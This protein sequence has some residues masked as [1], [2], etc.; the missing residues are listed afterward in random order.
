MP[1]LY[2]ITSL[3]VLSQSAIF[4]RFAHSHAAAIGLWRMIIAV[5][6]LALFMLWKKRWG[7]IAKLTRKQWLLLFLCGFFLF[8]H[9]FTWFLSVQKTSL[10]NSMVLFASNPLY[11]ALGAWAIFGEKI[12][13]RHMIALALCFLGVYFLMHESLHG[14]ARNFEGDVLGFI[15]SVLFSAYILTSKKIRQNLDNIPFAF[16]TY[17]FVGLFFL[18]IVLALGLPLYD[19]D[20]QTYMAFIGLA[21]GSTLLG[22]SLFTHCLKF[23]NVNVMSISTLVEPI[24]TAYMGYLLFREPI[25]HGA[26]LGFIFV[27]AGMLVLYMPGL[28]RKK[29]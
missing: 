27:V 28:K 5:P 7:D 25:T 29:S 10:A 11:T 20:G 2:L 22:H 4:I 24:I 23:F 1:Y 12:K 13:S 3:F 15:C 16:V 19:Y 17:S 18:A 6:I 14:T 26:V 9:F 21:I 8:S